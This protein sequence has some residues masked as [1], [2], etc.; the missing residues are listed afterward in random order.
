[1]L[2][3]KAAREASRNDETA[4]KLGAKYQ[5]YP[6]R[7]YTLEEAAARRPGCSFLR[8]DRPGASW[9]AEVR[10]FYAKIGQLIVGRGALSRRS[11]R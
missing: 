8:Q 1:M 3:A 4:A 10:E 5:L 6:N 9:E 7:I 2:K 11:G